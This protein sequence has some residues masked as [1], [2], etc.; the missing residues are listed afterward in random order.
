MT[1]SNKTDYQCLH[2][3]VDVHFKRRQINVNLEYERND[4]IFSW[5]RKQKN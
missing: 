3:Y 5:A 4:N 2:K 1:K